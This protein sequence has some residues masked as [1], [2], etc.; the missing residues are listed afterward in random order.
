MSQSIDIDVEVDSKTES[1]CEEATMRAIQNENWIMELGLSHRPSS[2]CEERVS[3]LKSSLIAWRK[4]VFATTELS[5]SG[6]F[7]P[8]IILPDPAIELIM[9]KV[10]EIVTEQKL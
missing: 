10:R 2:I 7:M 9:K 3:L 8:S 4:A 5:H 1:E 6:M